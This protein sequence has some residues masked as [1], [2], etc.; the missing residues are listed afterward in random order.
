VTQEEKGKS[1][2]RI[3]ERRAFLQNSAAAAV[4][5]IMTTAGH[6]R[7]AEIRRETI[8]YK[9]VGK[10]QI[11]AD[12]YVPARVKDLPIAVWIHGGALIMGDRRGIDRRLLAELIEAG[13]GVVSIDYRL[14]PETK[15]PAILDDLRDALAWVRASGPK[16]LG[17]RTDRIVVLGGSAGGYLT[18]V[19]GFLVSPRPSALVAFWGY[20]DIAGTW[21]S[22]PDP[23]YRRQPLVARS[24]AWATV[25]T[26]VIAEPS[27]DKQRSRFYLYCRQNGLWPKEVTGHDP[28]TEPKVF[29]GFCPVRNISTSYPP[30]LLVHGTDDT[31]VPHE[32]SVLMDRELSRHGV[33]HEF[34][35]VTGAGHGL[36]EASKADVARVHDRV[37]AFLQHHA[38]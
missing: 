37:K 27:P 26:E 33:P 14:A 4:S 12:L 6:A 16:H 13:Y 1:M 35:S 38:G 28:D 7:S 30:T 25:G 36:S 21:Y 29:D 11:K 10:C 8:T 20:G 23:F 24:E 22:R 34:V 5:M 3:W 15:L 18:L 19:S 9:T 17:S 32:Q 31:D 2:T